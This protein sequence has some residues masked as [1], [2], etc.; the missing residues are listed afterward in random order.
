MCILTCNV[1]PDSNL[2]SV[3]P[4]GPS[5]PGLNR[6]WPPGS[7]CCPA[8]RIMSRAKIVGF[9]KILRRQRRLRRSLN[10]IRTPIS[11]EISTINKFFVVWRLPGAQRSLPAQFPLVWRPGER[12]KRHRG[13][14]E[15]EL[16]N[17]P[18][19]LSLCYICSLEQFH[20]LRSPPATYFHLVPQHHVTTTLA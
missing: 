12:N 7:L 13:H 1:T 4:P 9:G 2:G 11:R 10:E 17:E 18:Q 6:S 3:T 14:F 19:N 20:S 15:A 8:L 16:P 5:T